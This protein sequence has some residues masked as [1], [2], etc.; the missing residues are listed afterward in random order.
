M[1]LKS[2]TLQ[3]WEVANSDDEGF[4]KIHDTVAAH[5]ESSPAHAGSHTRCGTG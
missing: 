5:D 1:F 3:N 2:N 4:S